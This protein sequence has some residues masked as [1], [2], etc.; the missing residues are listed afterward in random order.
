MLTKFN[1]NGYVI[2]PKII[3]DYL[4]RILRE[5]IAKNLP[6]GSEHGFR[7]LETKIPA[8]YKLAN[9]S[10]ITNIIAPLFKTIPQLVKAMYFNKIANANW[11]V[12]WHQDKTIAV[13]EKISLQGFKSWSIK[14]GVFHVQPPQEVM[15]N[16]V[17]I[18]INLDVANRENGCLKLVPKTHRLGILTPRQLQAIPQQENQIICNINPGDALVMSPLILHSSSKATKPTNRRVIHLEY[19]DY[20]LPKGLSWAIQ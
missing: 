9:S 12:P 10:E 18:R 5:K 14:E 17:T 19:S 4:V 20:R 3:N 6:L 7:Q 15:E 16:I 2:I 13:R 1:D 8:I 11:G